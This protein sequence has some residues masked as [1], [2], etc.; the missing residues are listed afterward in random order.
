MPR[1]PHPSSLRLAQNNRSASSTLTSIWAVVLTS[2]LLGAFYLG[3]DVLIPLALASLVT[4]LLAP[5]VGRLSRWIGNVGAV[6]VAMSLMLGATLG[7]GWSLGAQTIDFA[8]QLPSYKE[9][10]RVKI[11]SIRTPGQ[12]TLDRLSDT[13]EDLEKELPG[14]ENENGSR[15][16]R[17]D[18]IR[19]TDETGSIWERLRTMASPIV[20]P[21]G[22]ASL[23]FLL[24]AFMLLKREDLRS[25][26]IRLVGQGRISATTKA[27]DDAGTRVRRYL[28]MQLVVNVT[29]G[30]P[31]AIGLY[32]IGVPNAALWGALAAILRFVPYI[33]PWIAAIFPIL[34]S[35][36]VSPT[37][38]MPMQTMGLFIVLEL[39]SNNVLEPWL[40]GASTGVS[41]IALIV[42]AV[43]W[44]WMWGPVGLVLSTPFT[45]CLVVMGR[46]IPQLSFLSVVLGEEEALTPAEDC[47]HRLLRAGEHDELEFAESYLN[48]HQLVD[49]YDSVLIPVTISAEEDYRTAAID[50]EQ[51]KTISEALNELVNEVGERMIGA[52]EVAGKDSS[53]E[54]C[55]HCVSA[56]AARDDAAGIM[57][58][59]VLRL[60]GFDAQSTSASKGTGEAIAD[61]E[62]RLPELACISVVSPS[63]PV[64]ARNLLQRIR[65][66]LPEQKIVIGLWGR[67]DEDLERD[68][69]LLRKSGAEE[70]FTKI[71]D[72]ISYV[73]SSA[74]RLDDPVKPVPMP[75]D[76]EGRLRTLESLDL[77]EGEPE[78]VL[79]YISGKLTRVFDTP[80]TA[81]TLVDREFQW[82]KASTGLPEKLSN[83]GKIPRN[84]SICAHVV[85][86]DRMLVVRDLAR[87]RRFSKSAM[88]HEHGIRFYAGAPIHSAD[89]KVLGA[90]C[91]MSDAPRGFTAQE[92]RMLEASA[93][94]VAEEIERMAG[95]TL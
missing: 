6:I 15:R 74:T 24:S 22:T 48:N 90:L 42:S 19:V 62:D 65:Q 44:T 2:A 23:V 67:N 63:R 30:I 66:T 17:S 76:E 5:L 78:P 33:G 9:N 54:Y 21:L 86:S 40:Y 55:V 53:S 14:N 75:N 47:Y 58:A 72:F 37:W 46:H 64:H 92:K 32:I 16:S 11:R 80:I 20:G 12:G 57:A 61:L 45:V 1:P 93:A 68:V 60:Q 35:L 7:L 50:R 81:V 73:K 70:V 69:K 39:I 34:L 49:L 4:F 26:V 77:I 94:E 95:S 87:D 28:L 36:A 38:V 91:L 56:R 79:D 31:L 13:V 27:L 10:I 88:L 59:Q 29:Y 71:E 51:L 3:Q 43:F 25:R 84:Q 18:V 8:K 52:V 85:A 41:S 82:F 89:G 83:Q